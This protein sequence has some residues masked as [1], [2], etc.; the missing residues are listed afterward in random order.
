M[1]RGLQVELSPNEE[2]SLRRL[3]QKAGGREG[4]R[5]ENVTRLIALGLVEK[6]G[7]DLDLSPL[8][9]ERMAKLLG[10]SQRG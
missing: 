4:L 3:A 9:V 6:R 1:E 8:G 2:N 7:S 10:D 5:P